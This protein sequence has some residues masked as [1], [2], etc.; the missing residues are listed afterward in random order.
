MLCQG[1]RNIVQA[2]ATEAIQIQ[3]WMRREKNLNSRE[4]ELLIDCI[5]RQRRQKK[6]SK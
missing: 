5:G 2:H 1:C 3:Q 6:K 4:E